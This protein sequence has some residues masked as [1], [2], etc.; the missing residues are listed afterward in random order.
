MVFRYQ[1]ITW[2]CP[3]T[4]TYSRLYFQKQENWF[5]SI[6]RGSR[7]PQTVRRDRRSVVS[8]RLWSHVFPSNIIFYI[9]LRISKLFLQTSLAWR[10]KSSLLRLGV[11]IKTKNFML[12][13]WLSL[14]YPVS[15]VRKL[16][17]Q[18]DRR[19]FRRFGP[20]VRARWSYRKRS[21]GQEVKIVCDFPNS[22]RQKLDL[23]L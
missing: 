11:W 9:N 17:E 22:V 4:P 14:C 8:E 6:H 5:W 10:K 12:S 23:F 13:F 2:R 15:G 19:C 1:L 16:P 20:R 7:E 3:Y 18:H 21:R